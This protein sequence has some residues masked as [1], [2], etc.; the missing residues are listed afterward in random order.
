MR[1]RGG[2]IFFLRQRL[3]R[4]TSSNLKKIPVL[5]G[6]FLFV[7]VTCG[8]FVYF[9][10]SRLP[11]D[12]SA[13]VKPEGI[14]LLKDETGTLSFQNIFLSHQLIGFQETT[15]LL[16]VSGKSYFWARLSLKNAGPIAQ[17]VNLEISY[18]YLDHVQVFQVAAGK[19]S[20]RS[21][22]LSWAT[23]F[24]ARPYNHR[25]FI[26]PLTLPGKT[27]NTVYV[28]LQRNSGSLE[29]P[30]R[31]WTPENLL[32]HLFRESTFWGIFYGWLL[33]AAC[34]GIIL[35]GFEGSF[36]YLVYSFYTLSQLGTL[37]S[38]DAQW[39]D[40]YLNGQWGMHGYFVRAPFLLALAVSNLLFIRTFLSSKSYVPGILMTACRW[41]LYGVA[42][43][44]ILG[45][46]EAF[47]IVEPTQ[48]IKTTP[49]FFLHFLIITFLCAVLI[50]FSLFNKRHRPVGSLY[51]LAYSPL[52]LFGLAHGVTNMVGH[53]SYPFFNIKTLG[54]AIVF[55]TAVLLT[56]LAFRF[57]TYRDEREKLIQQQVELE[58]QTYTLALTSQQAERKRLARELHDGS[59]LDLAILKIKLSAAREQHPQ[60]SSLP[61][62]I[63]DVDRISANLRAVSH[64][65]M[66]VELQEKG[67]IIS[68]QELVDGMNYAKREIEVNFTSD[69]HIALTALLEQT[70][71]QIVKE[72]LANA[73]RHSGATL[74]DVEL[75]RQEQTL[76]ISLSDNG[77]GYDPNS[78]HKG[79]GL[80][81]IQASVDV[82]KGQFTIFRKTPGG[83]VHQILIP[84][85]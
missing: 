8:G 53:E 62:F 44:I 50:L 39:G 31:V 11:L 15:S 9:I 1:L 6:Y 80:S 72:L 77:C 25:Y 84:L 49:L 22:P 45:F 43:W 47:L 83:M 76:F 58:K 41:S 67:L 71:Y 20:Y 16:P 14:Q 46:L 78:Q 10:Q 54:G 42:G 12:D 59:G 57:K 19:V 56:G 34:F 23:P 18:P 17:K 13:E 60:F 29:I 28:R 66:P 21:A 64:S 38:H 32:Q 48:G 33:F 74:I 63:G 40:Y 85:F 36:L 52:L 2:V 79:L 73:I 51:L 35:F 68:L 5:F 70:V 81:N 3:G 4:L 27:S 65:L 69:E 61:E 30:I 7:V 26:F 82:L 24:K 37:V 55:E 75:Y